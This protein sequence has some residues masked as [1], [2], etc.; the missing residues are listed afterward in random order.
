MI[1]KV[2]IINS[3]HSHTYS[4]FIFKNLTSGLMKLHTGLNVLVFFCHLLYMSFSSNN[5]NH[6][7][8]AHLGWSMS[9]HPDHFIVRAARQITFFV[10]MDPPPFPR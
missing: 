5:N 8:T 1:N 7:I 2:L 4:S 10:L 6:A 9:K 3:P